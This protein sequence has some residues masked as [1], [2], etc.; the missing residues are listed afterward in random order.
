MTSGR[1]LRS[2]H[3]RYLLWKAA[4]GR[5][6]RCG[7]PLGED[8]QADH[9]TPWSLTHRTNVDE[10]QALCAA[11]NRKK[12]TMTLRKHQ[13]ELQELMERIEAKNLPAPK[14][15]C[16]NV[17]CGGGKS[18]LGVMAAH[19]AI[20][21]LRLAEKVCWLAPNGSLRFQAAQEFGKDKWIHRY[22]GHNLSIM[23]STNEQNPTK[24]TNGYATTYHAMVADAYGKNRDAF[25]AHSYILILD[26]AHHLALGSRFHHSVQPLVERAKMV[27]LFTGTRDRADKQRIAYL[28]YLKTGLVDPDNYADFRWIRYGIRDAVRE[29]AIIATHFQQI[30]GAARW[31]DLDGNEQEAT[32]FGDNKEA[33]F[34]AL[35]T[36]Y[37]LRLLD[38]CVDHWSN[39]RLSNRRSK[40]LVV[41][42]DVKQARDILAYLKKR[43]IS[44]KIATYREDDADL[45]ID[46]FKKSETLNVLVTV[47]KAYEGLD[48]P[49]ITHL[50]SL[51]HIRSR[52]WIEQMLGRGWRFDALAGPYES[53]V[54]YASVPDDL[55][56]QLVISDIEAEQQI[57]V[58][59]RLGEPRPAGPGGDEPGGDDPAPGI[60]PLSSGVTS[61]RATALLGE[62]QTAAATQVYRNVIE[63]M[64]LGLTPLQ[65]AQLERELAAERARAEVVGPSEP[66]GAPIITPRQRLEKFKDQ[67]DALVSDAARKMAAMNGT[68][69]GDEKREINGKLKRIYGSRESLTEEQCRNGMDWIR[70]MFDLDA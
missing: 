51:T 18:S 24:G 14:F 43:G 17:V 62:A 2:K 64:K 55:P 6:R 25:E 28:R 31:E 54:L 41:C 15:I 8:W 20:E 34:T 11:C 68:E 70:R 45:V 4:N 50:A 37:A 10:M 46:E 65:I 23:E 44:A 7:G 58:R 59:E 69:V 36:E 60:T 19:W 5:C 1:T 30:D 40:V 12:G 42:A 26:E 38:N 57:A 13:A 29:Q 48:A 16:A 33:L 9:I 27:F 61:T 67:L 39:Y 56:M 3:L 21:R 63:K 32:T 53:Q 49:S 35:R 22:T 66:V 52:S 47:A